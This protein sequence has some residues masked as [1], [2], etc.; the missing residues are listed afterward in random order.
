MSIGK[1]IVIIPDTQVRKGVPINHLEAAGNYIVRHKP[2]YVVC[3][4]DFEDMPSLNKFATNKEKEGMR[5][6]DDIAH[7]RNA[8][9]I[10]LKPLNDY[11]FKQKLQKR[12]QY[13]PRMIFTDGN[14]SS[15]V[16]IERFEQ[17]HP[18]VTGMMKPI[19]WSEWG[20]EVYPFLKPVEIEGIRFCHYFQN[21]HS[22]MGAPLGG[23]IDNML[24]NAGFSFVQGHTQG[25]KMGKHYLSDGTKRIGIVAGCLTPDHKVLTSDL[26]YVPIGELKVGDKLLSF[27]EHP[28]TDGKRSRRYKEGILLQIDRDMQEV[29]SVKLKSGKE[30]KVT[31]DH[32]WL[33]KTGS[34]YNWRMTSGL[35][36]GTQIPKLIDEW[37]TG[38]SFEEGWLSGIYDGEGSLYARSTTA[39]TVCQLGVSQKEGLIC[40]KIQNTLA[41]ICNIEV[42]R[43]HTKD[44]VYTIRGIGGVT[45]SAKILGQLRPERLLRKFKPEYLGKINCQNE[46][47]DTVISITP[48]GVQE[49]VKTDVDCKTLIVEGYPHHNS[50]YQHEETYMGYQGNKHWHGIIQLNE[51]KDGGGD[52]CELSLGYLLREY[53]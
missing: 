32:G 4:G 1:K 7:A 17:S 48:L 37:E 23:T 21:P 14:H 2:D 19:D 43:N 10:L 30:F 3:L 12:K 33:V 28:F 41:R 40:D 24:K 18:E 15:K 22:P 39:G 16:R 13:K 34:M 42:K 45:T 44:N 49:I 8:M 9:D 38:N 27:D 5:I 36:V 29:F 51:V 25:L 11:N 46:R 6:I 52:I 35:R 47:N 31:G 26:R 50:F 20:W 53:L